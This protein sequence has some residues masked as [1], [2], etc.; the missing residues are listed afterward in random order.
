[1]DEAL[2]SWVGGEQGQDPAEGVG[3]VGEVGRD[4]LGVDLLQLLQILAFL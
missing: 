4:N 3:I 2:G 1:M